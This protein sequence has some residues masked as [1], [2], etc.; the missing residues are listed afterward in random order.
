MAENC[1]RR[2][3]D[4]PAIIFTQEN[5]ITT[6]VTWHDLYNKVARLAAKLRSDGLTKG[7]RV[8]AFVANVPETV[9]AMLATA[10][11]GAIWSSVS[12]DFGS[13]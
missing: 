9:V 10:S 5:V 4:S 8:C 13:E 11:I 3:D 6:T 2:K 7:D 1:L 12:P